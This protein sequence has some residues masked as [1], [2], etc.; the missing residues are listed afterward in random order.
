[1][2]INIFGC[3]FLFSLSGAAMKLMFPMSVGKGCKIVCFNYLNTPK[4]NLRNEKEINF[5]HAISIKINELQPDVICLMK[6]SLL[7]SE[8]NLVQ[9]KFWFRKNKK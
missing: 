8:Q 9:I 7:W 4:N 2:L 5:L 3:F 6:C 1:M